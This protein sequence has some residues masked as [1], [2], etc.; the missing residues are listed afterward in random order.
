MLGMTAGWESS[1]DGRS[2]AVLAGVAGKSGK[3]I[4]GAAMLPTSGRG[5][6]QVSGPAGAATGFVPMALG[7][8]GG[9]VA[10]IRANRTSAAL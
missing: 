6:E 1:I 10:A 3:G 4:H 5:S 9:S 7:G 2:L 8:S